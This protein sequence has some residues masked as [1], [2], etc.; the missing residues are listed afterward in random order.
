MDGGDAESTGADD[1]MGAAITETMGVR[2]VRTPVLLDT[3][4]GTDIT[5]KEYAF[6]AIVAC[7][8]THQS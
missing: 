1:E 7:L 5:T 2:V 6:G 4:E 3:L 8:A